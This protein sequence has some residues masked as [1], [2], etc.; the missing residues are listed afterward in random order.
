[1][2]FIIKIIN[3]NCVKYNVLIKKKLQKTI[4]FG[5][6]G[7]QQLTIRKIQIFVFING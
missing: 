1:M 5:L 6:L 7:D 4:K 3:A 2:A